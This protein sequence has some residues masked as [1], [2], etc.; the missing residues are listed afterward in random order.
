MQESQPIC[1]LSSCTPNAPSAS[2]QHPKGVLLTFC[3]AVGTD[4]AFR[5]V[6]LAD[7]ELVS[8]LTCEATCRQSMQQLFCSSQATLHCSVSASGRRS[9]KSIPPRMPL[10][11]SAA[12]CARRLTAPLSRISRMIR[13]SSTPLHPSSMISTSLSH[14]PKCSQSTC[15]TWVH[16]DWHTSVNYHDVSAGIQRSLLLES[17]TSWLQTTSKW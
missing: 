15:N 5:S 10:P 1:L 4:S 9:R 12:L 7:P 8:R 11:F 13:P 17:W 6:E 16:C 3:R 2:A 14:D